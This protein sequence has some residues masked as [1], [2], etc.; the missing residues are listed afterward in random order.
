[1]FNRNNLPYELLLIT[2]QQTELRNAIGKNMSNDIKLSRAQIS[3]IIQSW[4][5]LS[6]LLSKLEDPLIKVAVPFAKIISVPLAITA[7]VSEID[8]EIQKKIYVSGITTLI[9]NE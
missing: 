6:S 1:M 3:K 9:M 4:R 2:Q 7:D 5:F 8:A